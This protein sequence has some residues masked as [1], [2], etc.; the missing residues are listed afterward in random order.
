MGDSVIPVHSMSV[1]DQQLPTEVLAID[2]EN[3]LLSAVQGAGTALDDSESQ[4]HTP[5]RQ[6]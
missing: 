2:R 1:L 5:S 4:R 6:G 3:P